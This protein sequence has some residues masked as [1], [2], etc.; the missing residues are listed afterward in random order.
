M[1]SSPSALPAFSGAAAKNSACNR[2]L[3]ATADLMRGARVIR[4]ASDVSFWE[5]CRAK[6]L[7]GTRNARCRKV[8]RLFARGHAKNQKFPGKPIEFG[9]VRRQGADAERTVGNSIV[10]RSPGALSSSVSLP[11]CIRA[12]AEARLSPR[13]GAGF[14]AALLEPDEPSDHP[15]AIGF[16][17]ARPLVTDG[18]AMSC[19][20]CRA[21]V[22]AISCLLAVDRLGGRRG[23]L[24]RIV[25]EIG[26]RLADQFA[27][28]L[29]RRRHASR[30]AASGPA[31][32]ATGS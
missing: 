25:E 22:T 27:I 16:R 29:H 19:R 7:S 9:L 31:S 2:L 26:E 1:T 5:G 21:T 14:R 8:V 17:N 10:A 28:A 15:F 6:L 3:A 30:P 20:H 4:R 11:P 24:D 13:P 32:S 18:Q 23:I 12:T